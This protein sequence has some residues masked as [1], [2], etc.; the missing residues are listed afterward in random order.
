MI[1]A[2]LIA[3]GAELLIGR[4]VNTHAQRLGLALAPLGLGLA[5]ETTLRDDPDAIAGAVRDALARST[6]IFVTGGLGPTCDDL[7]REALA[8]ALGRGIVPDEPSLAA[9]R[10]RCARL[11]Q[12]MTDSRARQAGMLEGAA[13][14]SN[15]VGAAPGQRIELDGGRVLFVL[16]GPPR[17][18]EAI[19]AE[20]VLPWLRRRFPGAAVAERVLMVCG[21]GES[22]VIERFASAGFD[23]APLELAYC[24]GPG[25]LEIRLTGTPGS[26]AVLETAAARAKAALGDNVYA[27]TREDL[28]VVVGRRLRSAGLTVGTA[29]SCTGGLV[30]QCI[31]AVPGSSAWFRGAI[32]A[33]ANDVKERLLGVPAGVLKAHGAVSEPVARAM[34]EGARSRLGTDIALATTGVAGPDGGTPEKPVGLVWWALADAKGTLSRSR[35]FPGDRGLIRR[36]T[37]QFALDLLRRRLDGHA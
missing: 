19:L 1:S 17:E 11:G 32:V 28:A 4:T 6:V 14:L 12:P 29:E 25:Q 35:R 2:E 13:A 18:F 5:R 8:A 20:H 27:E 3:T 37:A 31:T 21:L 22:D 7:T 9:I 10:E 34:A 15:S 36:W 23:P 30:A 24:A 16:P 26:E 33:Y